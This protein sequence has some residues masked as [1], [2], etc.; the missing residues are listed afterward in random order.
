MSINV[1]KEYVQ[2]KAWQIM[3]TT[4]Y[5]KY[6]TYKSQAWQENQLYQVWLG[7]IHVKEYFAVIKPINE[8]YRKMLEIGRCKEVFWRVET[9][10][11]IKSQV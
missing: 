9:V 1:V 8:C 10:W 3:H 5:E 11:T 7:R 4:A 6:Q 2:V